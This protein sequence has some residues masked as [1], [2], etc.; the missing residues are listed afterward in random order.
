L[1]SVALDTS[2]TGCGA[3][4][5][6]VPDRTM[7]VKRTFQRVFGVRQG[8]P[9]NLDKRLLAA[10]MRDYRVLDHKAL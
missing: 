5:S 8:M 1:S 6:K 7:A 10:I 2:C 4:V 9:S 3:P